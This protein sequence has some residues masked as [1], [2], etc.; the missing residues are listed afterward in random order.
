MRTGFDGD[1]KRFGEERLV[2]AAGDAAPGLAASLGGS[3]IDMGL[4]RCQ[5]DV[6]R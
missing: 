5:S 2:V 4:G 6:A 1:R 3:G